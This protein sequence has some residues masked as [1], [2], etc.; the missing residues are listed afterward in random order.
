MK[1]VY[2]MNLL[3]II[4][5][6]STLSGCKKSVNYTPETREELRALVDNDT[7]KLSSINTSKIT[8]MSKLFANVKRTDFSGIENWDTSKVTNMEAMF[9][10]AVTFNSDISK[11]NVSNVVNMNS[12]FA[13]ATS[14]NQNIGLWN[15]SQV[16]DMMSMFAFALSFNKDLSKW[17]VADNVTKEGAFWGS[18][19]EN[20]PPTW[21]N[22]K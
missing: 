9:L 12:M 20:N 3:L 19:L 1:K 7:V 17:K 4:L 15:V 22:K 5:L 14:F 16:E 2:L 6:I 13:G 18:P 11:W 21:F 10:G 8:D